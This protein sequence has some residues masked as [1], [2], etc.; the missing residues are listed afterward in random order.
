MT[1]TRTVHL[2]VLSTATWSMALRREPLPLSCPPG[3]TLTSASVHSLSGA[4]DL[5]VLAAARPMAMW[6]PH[7]GSR[8]ELE[9]ISSQ[10]Q[11][12]L[13]AW[14]LWPLSSACCSTWS[15]NSGHWLYLGLAKEMGLVI[16]VNHS[17][18]SC[19]TWIKPLS[20]CTS[21]CHINLAFVVTGSRTSIFVWLTNTIIQRVW[22]DMEQM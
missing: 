9:M 12:K 1:Y 5:V 17:P 20:L 10:K 19:C 22:E 21:I 6:A 18:R 11:T 13:P 3:D 2:P 16:D 15:R 4:H 14:E 8:R 7:A